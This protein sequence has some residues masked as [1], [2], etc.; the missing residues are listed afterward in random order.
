[1]MLTEEK[2]TENIIDHEVRIRMQ[3]RMANDI[4]K[5]LRYIL[6]TLIGSILIPIG[7]KYFNLA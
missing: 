3:E 1:M 5:L 4:H 6:V 2:L 7:L